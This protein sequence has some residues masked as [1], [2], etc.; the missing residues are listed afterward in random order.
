MTVNRADS[1]AAHQLQID[2]ALAFGYLQTDDYQKLVALAASLRLQYPRAIEPAVLE[3][4][5]RSQLQEVDALEK[6]IAEYAHTTEARQVGQLA[7][8]GAAI[9]AGRADS[10]PRSKS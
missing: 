6:L 1:D 7:L 3:M 4:L 10:G 8:A 5:T 2:R 9:A